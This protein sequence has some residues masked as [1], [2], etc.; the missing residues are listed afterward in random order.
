MKKILFQIAYAA[1]LA[2]AI[3]SC[4][5][6]IG[7]DD[8]LKPTKLSVEEQKQK[9]EEN[10]IIL[11]DDME[12]MKNTQAYKTLTDFASSSAAFAVAP[13][14]HLKSAMESRN[15]KTIDVL[16]NQM[17]SLVAGDE[18]IWGEYVW[19]SSY[20]E[21]EKVSNL[22]NQIIYKF[23]ASSTDKLNKAIV[24]INYAESNI[25]I[26]EGDVYYPS[27]VDF[28][29]TVDGTT[30]MQAS[31]EGSY[32]TD[33]TP[34][35]AKNT[36]EMEDYKWKATYTNNAKKV[37]TEYEFKYK[38]ETLIKFVTEIN[39][40]LNYNELQDVS[41]DENIP[42]G[43][44]S[45]GSIYFQMMNIAVLAGT[46]DA[47]LLVNEINDL[48]NSSDNFSEEEYYD[49]IAEILNN[50]LTLW[51]CFVDDKRKFAD[52]EFYANE[53]SDTW[54]QSDY[55]W[56]GS[57]YEYVETENTRTYYEIIPRFILN[58]GSKVD[59]EE[60]VQAGFDDFLDRLEDATQSMAND[61][62]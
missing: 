49:K 36:L 58:D 9:I 37:S 50:N 38:S 4:N 10:G 39:G 32:R 40:D 14:N 61:L 45:S 55:V 59:I 18:D 7:L 44:I 17:R 11:V 51:S 54:Y 62:D 33:G 35:D 57:Y 48:E 1:I 46:T 28:D 19:N 26:P 41:N 15:L 43:L 60:F 16:N 22:S 34:V 12:G 21:F 27:T 13:M 42:S 5:Q 23:P 8:N 2:L 20:E 6:Q 53:Y 29:F 30:V 3:S 31:F 47:E 56:N 52:V 24:T 25:E